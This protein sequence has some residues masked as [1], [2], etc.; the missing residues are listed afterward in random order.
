V[1]ASGLARGGHVPRRR[2]A[3]ATLAAA[4]VIPLV[5][6]GD[7]SF[8]ND[9]PMLV[10]NAV[11]ANVAGRLAE[12]GL[13]GTFGVTYGPFPTWVYQ[14]LTAIS[15]DL[16]V[17]AL[18]HAAVM[19][20]ATA[21]ALWWL[22]GSLRLWP[23]FA[24]VPLLSPYFWFYARVLWDN[25]FLIPLG[26][27]AVAGYAANLTTDSAWGLRVALAAMMA[28]LL[29][30]LMGVALV[31]PL[32]LHMVTVRGR[33]L[34]S[35]RISV[36]VIVLGGA[37][38]AWPYWRSLTA[39][40]APSLAVPSIDGLLLPLFGA[41]LLSARQLEYLFGAGPVSGAGL[42]V[43]AALSF[44]VYLLTW[45]GMA[46]A[47][48]RLAEAIRSRR[49]Y[50]HAPLSRGDWT[51]RT[52]IAAI[53]LGSLAC[54]SV[55]DAFSGK[56][57][58]PHYYN[59]TWIAFTL[60]AWFAVDFIVEQR[61]AIRRSAVAATGLLAGVLLVAVATIAVRLHISSGTRAVYGPTISNQQRVAR[62]LARYAPD[63]RVVAQVDLYVRYP[64][65]LAILRELNPGNGKDRPKLRLEVR[66]ASRDPASGA[67]EVVAR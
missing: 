51:A 47:A 53:L 43:A 10:I 13:L 39:Q 63:S 32:A 15:H 28:I 31:V 38:L 1:T 29:V 59:G 5:W 18:L 41:R 40:S 57:E 21:G 30:H 35:L 44:L 9:E 42:N 6:T 56:F 52:H 19:S 22:S 67:I 48:W 64:H 66:Y 58:H 34:W 24:A 65:T 16:V 14:A 49:S 46:L 3:L 33:A 11:R 7:I 60:L 61:P 12:T 36:A 23:W 2:A 25:P 26:A 4:C 62:T 45:G 27:L 37:A 55:I 54:Q 8:I 50:V 20:A 17:V